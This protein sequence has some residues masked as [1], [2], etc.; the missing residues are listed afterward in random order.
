MLAEKCE[1][2]GYNLNYE[3]LTHCSDDC[4]FTTIEKTKSISRTPFEK[5]DADNYWF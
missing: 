5:W 1:V 3:N 4:L 2:C